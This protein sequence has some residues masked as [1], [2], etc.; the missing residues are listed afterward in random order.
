[1]RCDSGH[2]SALLRSFLLMRD[3]VIDFQPLERSGFRGIQPEFLDLFAEV[4]AL[5]RMLVET[6]CLCFVSPTFNLFGHFLFATL[7]EPFHDFLVACALLDLHF[8]ILALH[9]FETEEHI[10]ERTVEVIFAN[11]SRYQSAAL[12]DCATE[13]CVTA[14]A[15]P[16]TTWRFLG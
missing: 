9:T 14:N 11:I 3:F 4:V 15:D 12:I 13:S 1:M 5:F 16:R 7:I 10:I 2:Y 6:A 8:E